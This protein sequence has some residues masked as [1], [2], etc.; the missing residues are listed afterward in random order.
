M[1]IT[2]AL[3]ERWFAPTHNSLTR[4][5]YRQHLERMLTG[6]EVNLVQQIFSKY[7]NNQTVTWSSTVAY[8]QVYLSSK[9]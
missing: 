8:L 9:S 6:D 4:P 1:L 5:T 7:L 3:V 2:P